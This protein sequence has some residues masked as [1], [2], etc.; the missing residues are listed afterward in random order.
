MTD[1]ELAAAFG[2][3]RTLCANIIGFHIEADRPSN[4]LTEAQRVMYEAHVYAGGVALAWRV[5]RIA[6]ELERRQP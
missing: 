5:N 4:E 1:D 2:E 6:D 3:L